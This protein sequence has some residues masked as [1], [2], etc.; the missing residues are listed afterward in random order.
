MIV[1]NFIISHLPLNHLYLILFDDIICL[2]WGTID[3]NLCNMKCEYQATHLL[4]QV[5]CFT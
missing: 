1:Y 5:S 2:L 4:I 3:L